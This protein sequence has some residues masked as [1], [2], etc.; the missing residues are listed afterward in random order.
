MRVHP[1]VQSVVDAYL[2]AID[3]E[4]PGLVEGF[5][6]TGSVALSDF[7]PH[8]SDIDFV[9]VMV[10]RPDASA[11]AALRRAHGRLRKRWPQPYF[12]GLYVTWD[13][14]A[15]DPASTRRGPY[16]YMGRFHERARGWCEPVTWHT[17]ARHGIACRGPKPTALIIRVDPEQLA[18]WTLNNLDSYWRPLLSG[19]SGFLNRQSLIALT[20]YGAAWI[21]LGISRLHC[22]LATGDICSKHAAGRYA[23]QTFPEQWRPVLNEC[24]RIRQADRAR[25]DLVSALTETAADLRI[26]SDADGGSLYRTPLTRRRDV[27]GFGD[28]VVAD[29]FRRYG[30]GLGT[31]DW[32]L[33]R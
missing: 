20:S 4:A 23:L 8:T 29:A 12:D 27:L 16:S 31:R 5:Y 32:A 1:L 11:I 15:R 26:R 24:L 21:V 10:N 28:M 3:A 19:S 25:A 9:A 18:L 13:E 2:S 7:R 6:L 30:R 17:L 14:L 22:T 33:G